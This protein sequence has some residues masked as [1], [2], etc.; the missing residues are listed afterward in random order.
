MRP[1]GSQVPRAPE[2]S[3]LN[4][5]YDDIVT[6]RLVRYQG[7]SESEGPTKSEG[8]WQRELEKRNHLEDYF[9]EQL[10]KT[11]KEDKKKKSSKKESDRKASKRLKKRRHKKST[12]SESESDSD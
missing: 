1:A 8:Y 2:P 9:P 7:V 5:L 4:R 6:S 3:T 10:K 12:S 11:R